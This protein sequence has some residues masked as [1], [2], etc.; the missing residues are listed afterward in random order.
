MS[1]YLRQPYISATGSVMKGGGFGLTNDE[2]K[3]ALMR[4]AAILYINPKSVMPTVDWCALNAAVALPK[5][6]NARLMW[7]G[8]Y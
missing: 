8:L 6:L 4:S 3:R 5:Y 1:D 7:R 2:I